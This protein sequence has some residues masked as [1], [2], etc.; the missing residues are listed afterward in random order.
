MIGWRIQ[1]K[2]HR[3]VTWREEFIL[4]GRPKTW[5]TAP[6]TTL[7]KGETVAVTEKTVLPRQGWIRNA[8]VITE[9]DPLGPYILKVWI[10]G[11][12]V[13][14]FHFALEPP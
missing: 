12:P 1:L 3:R 7:A 10:Q 5:G 2:A 8:W 9:G 13:K 6:R 14:T 11:T 4:P